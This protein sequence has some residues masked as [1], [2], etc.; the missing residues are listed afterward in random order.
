MLH[1]PKSNHRVRFVRYR[2]PEGG[3]L[4]MPPVAAPPEAS[5]TCLVGELEAWSLERAMRRER[6]LRRRR[7]RV[8][9]LRS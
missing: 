4:L 2:I 7:R 9:L 8:G 1:R 3:S 5:P 6:R